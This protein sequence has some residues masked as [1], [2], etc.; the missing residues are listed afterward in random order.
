MLLEPVE[1]VRPVMWALLT[2]IPGLGPEPDVRSVLFLHACR[3]TE[4][5]FTAKDVRQNE[6]AQGWTNPNLA[7][8]CMIRL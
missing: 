3:E 2:R 6:R 4:C 5:R 1:D 7:K 8:E